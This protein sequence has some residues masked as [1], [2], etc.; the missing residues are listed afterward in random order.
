M[1]WRA[2]TEFTRDW[3][4]R[5]VPTQRPSMCRSATPGCGLNEL[6][7]MKIQQLGIMLIVSVA[8]ALTAH[9]LDA[10]SMESTE[11]RDDWSFDV[12]PYL[13]IAGYDGSFSVPGVPAGLSSTQTRSVDS[14]TTHISAAAMLAGQVRYRDVGLYLEGAWLQLKT[15][16]G[17]S[18]GLYSGTDI[19]TDIAFGTIAGLYR[20]PRTGKLDV[21]LVAGA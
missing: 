2:S 14:L 12:A 1:S 5:S 4:W 20:L 8:S 10:T 7:P 9:A 17:T 21:D 13:W 16:G 11:T 3:T 6:N 19:K 15:E 18:S